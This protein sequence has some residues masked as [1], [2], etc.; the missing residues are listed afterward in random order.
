MIRRFIQFDPELLERIDA[1]RGDVPFAAWVRRACE[2]RLQTDEEL[3]CL[4]CKRII[5]WDGSKAIP[6]VGEPCLE[7]GCI[8]DQMT[9]GEWEAFQKG[10]G[11]KTPMPS[12]P[13]ERTPHHG[14]IS[15]EHVGAPIP[16]QCGGVIYQSGSKKGRCSKCS[17]PRPA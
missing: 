7:S 8:P 15:R 14:Y 3:R 5:R 6:L 16:C 17:D 1:V 4:A 12:K 13:I 10:A 2:A 11:F 9:D